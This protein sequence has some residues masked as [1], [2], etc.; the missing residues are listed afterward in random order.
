LI[1]AFPDGREFGTEFPIFRPF[2][3]VPDVNSY[4]DFSASHANSLP[5]LG[6][7]LASLGQGIFHASA[8][9]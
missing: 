6:R 4:Y 5:G 9:S 3:A 2:L 8:G 1:L 7:E